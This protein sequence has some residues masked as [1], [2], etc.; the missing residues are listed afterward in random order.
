MELALLNTSIITSDEG[1][2][3]IRPISTFEARALVRTKTTISAI[4]HQSTADV[5]TTLLGKRIPVNRIKFAQKPG[6]VA[7]VFKLNGRP[8]EG[9]ILTVDEIDEIGYRFLLLTRTA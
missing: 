8:P 7:L 4:G 2:Y 9:K 6:Q 3:Y 5:M 1:T